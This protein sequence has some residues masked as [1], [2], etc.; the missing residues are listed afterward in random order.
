MNTTT[1]QAYKPAVPTVSQLVGALRSSPGPVLMSAGQAADYLEALHRAVKTANGF[2]AQG[3]PGD[4][5][6]VLH[7][8]LSVVGK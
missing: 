1:T 6:V 2:L 7:D 4:A 3:R 8:A 5:A